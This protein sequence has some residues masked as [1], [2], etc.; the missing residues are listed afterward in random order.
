MAFT[1]SRS[2]R[3]SGRERSGV[4]RMPSHQR[5]RNWS[6]FHNSRRQRS[7]VNSWKPG[8]HN[9]SSLLGGVADRPFPAI[10]PVPQR[11]N[12]VGAGRFRPRELKKNLTWSHCSLL[13]RLGH[14]GRL[15]SPS[16]TLLPIYNPA[17]GNSMRASNIK[18]IARRS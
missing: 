17:L 12:P 13:G 18:G 2:T 4:S 11:L 7:W 9:R 3:S 8:F 1:S 6:P 14:F 10:V 5:S 15:G 16:T